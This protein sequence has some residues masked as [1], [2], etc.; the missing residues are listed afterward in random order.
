MCD[1]KQKTRR[2]KLEGIQGKAK[3]FI[4]NEFKQMDLPTEMLKKAYICKN[5]QD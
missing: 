4:F 5:E 1:K 3:R 2:L